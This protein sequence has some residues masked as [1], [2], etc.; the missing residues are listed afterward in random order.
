MRRR[1]CLGWVSVVTLSF[2]VG[3]L[4]A[5]TA[6]RRQ[7]ES[8]EK[9]IEQDRFAVD[10]A[11]P[12]VN[13]ND[14]VAEAGSA[15]LVSAPGSFQRPAGTDEGIAVPDDLAHG[16][17]NVVPAED[18]ADTTPRTMIRIWGSGK[19]RA[20]VEVSETA[21]RSAAKNVAAA[22]Q[23]SDAAAMHAYE[24]ALGLLN[25]HSYEEA[26]GAL[27]TFLLKWPTDPNAGNAIYWQA[28][29]YYSIGEYSLA[30][31]QL[32]Q[33]LESYPTST[34]VPDCL[35]K[36]GLCQQKLGDFVKAKGYFQR[37]ETEYPR[38]EAAHR[39]PTTVT[40]GG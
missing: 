3:C 27:G 23:V 15:H 1:A 8:L 2:G 36:L 35:L 17:A 31:E 20:N 30:S 33:A 32:E 25:A 12:R 7:L 4:S 21:P 39:I 37:L 29:C 9:G 14:D 19:G 11:S 38:S 16:A 24:A 34:R 18:P 6:E 10:K 13:E 40:S 5:E 22:S 26:A 28:E